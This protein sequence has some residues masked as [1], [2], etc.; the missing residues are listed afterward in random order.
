M[1]CLDHKCLEAGGSGG[2]EVGLSRC[3][4]LVLAQRAWARARLHTCVN[5]RAL[6]LPNR[7]GL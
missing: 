4:A 5:T 1:R 6:S 2:Q 7:T 3:K